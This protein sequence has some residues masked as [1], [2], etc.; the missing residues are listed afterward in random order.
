[1]KSHVLNHYPYAASALDAGNDKGEKKINLKCK[2]PMWVYLVKQKS[3]NQ[4]HC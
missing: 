1:M 3:T 4:M 2:N